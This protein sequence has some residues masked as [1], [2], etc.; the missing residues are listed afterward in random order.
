MIQQTEQTTQ[1]PSCERCQR[2]DKL[3]AEALLI[4]LKQYSTNDIHT[5]VCAIREHFGMTR[6]G[7]RT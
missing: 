1:Q 2:A 4:L 7:E 5:V 3:L 6:F